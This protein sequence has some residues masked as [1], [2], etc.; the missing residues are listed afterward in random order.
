[1]DIID[2]ILEIKNI[3]YTIKDILNINKVLPSGNFKENKIIA[4]KLNSLHEKD[5]LKNMII[6]S[7]Y[8]IRS[9]LSTIY[10]EDDIVEIN[11]YPIYIVISI[12]NEN[13]IEFNEC[14]S[15]SIF[16]TSTK[17]NIIDIYDIAYI[18]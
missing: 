18:D 2:K 4:I 15:R 11:K 10:K 13:N 3:K 9:H 6:V 1:M 5:Y 8:E 14:T 12:I 17:V 16:N 7:G